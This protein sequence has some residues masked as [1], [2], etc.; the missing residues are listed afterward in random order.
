MLTKLLRTNLT[1]WTVPGENVTNP[2]GKENLNPLDDLS[3]SLHPWGTR[4]PTLEYGA[5]D[6][7]QYGEICPSE[8][9]SGGEWAC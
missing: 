2:G 6:Y 7:E 8:G 1:L 3:S 5:K 4:I 9:P